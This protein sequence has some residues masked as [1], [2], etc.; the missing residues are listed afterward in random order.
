MD[1]KKYQPD[2]FISLLKR[3]DYIIRYENE[4]ETK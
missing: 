2:G 4:M 1:L 3:F